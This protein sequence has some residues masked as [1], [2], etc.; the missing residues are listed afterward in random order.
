MG[1]A[2][3]EVGEDQVA[4]L[5][6]EHH[7]RAGSYELRSSLDRR[8]WHCMPWLHFGVVDDYGTIVQSNVRPGYKI[9]MRGA[10]KVV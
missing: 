3:E 8:F 6:D 1:S 7:I 4:V 2:Y 9:P 10:E 5:R